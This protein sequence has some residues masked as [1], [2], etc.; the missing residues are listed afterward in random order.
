MIGTANLLQA[1]RDTGHARAVV[2]V[3]TDKVY[4]DQGSE[5]GY[6]E[7]DRLGG[8]DPYSS[9]KVCQEHVTGAFRDSLLADRGIAVATARA[10]NVIGGGDRTHGRLIPDL[11][12]AGLDGTPLEVRAPDAVRPW[13]HVLNPLYGYLLLAEKLW[14]D[15]TYATAW[16][17]GPDQEESRPVAW[18]VERMRARWPGELAVEFAERRPLREAAVPRVDSTRART[19]LGW[20]PPWDLARGDRRHRRLAPR[21]PRRSRPGRDLPR[22]DRALHGRTVAAA[23]GAGRLACLARGLEA[24]PC[25]SLGAPI[26]RRESRALERLFPLVRCGTRSILRTVLH[27]SGL[28]RRVWMNL[29]DGS[30]C[31]VSERHASCEARDARHGGVGSTEALYAPGGTSS[32][33]RSHCSRSWRR[34]PSG[35]AVTQAPQISGDLAPGPGSELVASPGGWTPASATATYD[36]LRCKASGTDCNPVPGSCERNYTVRDADLGHRLRVRLTVTEPGQPHAFG[37]SEPTVVV[38]DKPYSIPTP[39]RLRAHL[40]R[41]RR[42]RGRDRARL[43]PA[44]RAGRAPLPC[45]PPHCRSSSPFPIVRIS[46]RFKGKRT[47]LTRVTVNAPRGARIRVAC[48]GRGCPYRR[49]AIAVEL[50]RVRALQRTYRP[51]ATIEIRVTQPQKIG[52]YTRMRT[53]KGKGPRRIDRCL[54][55]GKTRPVKCPTA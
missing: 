28:A 1:I 44:A 42:R 41:G 31:Q 46:G 43:P 30:T 33:S 16:N 49:R 11:I 25:S 15:P 22:A 50:V 53:R 32:S 37:I 48:K 10:G 38:I 18:L 21:P 35:R 27:L 7:D 34:L 17:F 40:R 2:S 26:R 12:R 52:K 54:M 23:R 24:E 14:E 19:R 8:S 3:T 51:K 13:Q 36:W 39:G 55:P 9:S 29:A 6:R 20:R 4:L 47:K 45:R 5:W